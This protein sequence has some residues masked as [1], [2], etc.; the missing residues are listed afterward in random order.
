[1]QKVVG[2]QDKKI[3]MELKDLLPPA[4]RSKTSRP[5]NEVAPPFDFRPLTLFTRGDFS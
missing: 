1:M 5:V 4:E 3:C 2:V